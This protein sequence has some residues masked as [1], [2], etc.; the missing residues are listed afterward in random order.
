MEKKAKAGSEKLPP[1]SER[2]E[3]VVSMVTP[4]MTAADI[5]CDHGYVSI[6]LYRSGR[7]PKCI[8]AD[9]NAGPLK[10][11]EKNIRLYGAQEGVQARLSDGLKG[12]EAGEAECVIISGM[13]GGLIT[14]I[15]SYDKEK[16]SSVKE[17]VLEPQSDADKVRRYLY[18]NGYMIA[19]EALVT[20]RGKYYPVI[21]AVKA[22][23]RDRLTEEE[24]IFGP[25]LI[26][27]GN[28]LLKEY[29]A[30]ERRRI[31]SVI[32]GLEGS[33]SAAAKE[34]LRC[35][36]KEMEHIEKAWKDMKE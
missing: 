12:I 1:L 4:E 17:L 14:E 33:D 18:E 6:F 23:V 21:K 24:Y 20:E 2:M 36:K 31:G 26:K 13:G 11:A 5:G 34:R 29:L 27:D 22:S 25:C 35:L 15:L 16:T 19:K 30:K 7:C 9:V 3:T 8:A 28:P 32:D 10:A